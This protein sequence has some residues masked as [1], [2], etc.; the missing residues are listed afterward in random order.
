MDI[1]Y[2]CFFRKPNNGP[3]KPPHWA[4]QEKNFWSWF[5]TRIIERPP[6]YEKKIENLVDSIPLMRLQPSTDKIYELL[7]PNYKSLT[8]SD[9]PEAVTK[10]IIPSVGNRWYE[11]SGNTLLDVARSTVYK[12]ASESYQSNSLPSNSDEV[13]VEN[14]SSSEESKH[15]T[16]KIHGLKVESKIDS[17]SWIK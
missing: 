17:K 12:I 13:E 15:Q 3:S 11:F 1:F 14:S 4:P 7:L 6:N 2:V 9:A 8:S 5:K 10:V 16:T